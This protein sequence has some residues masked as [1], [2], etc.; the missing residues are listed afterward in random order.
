MPLKTGFSKD[1]FS[2]NV[3]T[4]MDS[5]RSRAQSLAIA[6]AQKRKA[7]RLKRMWRGGYSAGGTVAPDLQDDDLEVTGHY[8]TTGEPHT[9]DLDGEAHPMEF[10][11]DGGMIDDMEDETTGPPMGAKFQD[12][13]RRRHR[14][15]RG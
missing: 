10:M 9:E 7:E 2:H 8:N 4:E 14:R 13:L 1:T 3:A 15:F 6:Y 12:A 11:A 5:G